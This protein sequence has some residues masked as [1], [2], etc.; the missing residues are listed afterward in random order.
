MCGKVFQS[1]KE[2]IVEEFFSRFNKDIFHNQLPL[3]LSIR[4]SNTLNKTAGITLCSRVGQTYTAEIQ[5]AKKVVDN[6]DKLRN[7]LCHELCHA[8]SWL[9]DHNN[10]P[11]HGTN[12]KKWAR[13]AEDA[14]P[15][16]S[17]RTCHNYHIQYKY[18]VGKRRKRY[19]LF[20]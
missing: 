15:G 2:E 4:W 16:L 17:I 19:T 9:I 12:F 18:Q 7:T 6:S 13:K 8:A 5:L 10:A 11:P 20:L 14:F 1:H 3:D